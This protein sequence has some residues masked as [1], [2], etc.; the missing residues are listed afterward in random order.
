MRQLSLLG[1]LEADLRV[2]ARAHYFTSCNTSITSC[3]NLPENIK[4]VTM[5]NAT[6]RA[7]LLVQLMIFHVKLNI[8]QKAGKWIRSHTQR[9]TEVQKLLKKSFVKDDD[10]FDIGT[11]AVEEQTTDFDRYDQSKEENSSYLS[12]GPVGKSFCGKKNKLKFKRNAVTP[13]ERHA[14]SE[15]SEGK[16]KKRH[17][18]TLRLSGSRS[19]KASNIKSDFD[20]PYHKN[21]DVRKPNDLDL[22]RHSAV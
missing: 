7:S 16:G 2:A 20:K 15:H 5:A 3:A 18:R 22:S 19:T 1:F 8:L 12:K 6:R 10:F 11:D 9:K 17:S 4:Q 21:A 14:W 13:S